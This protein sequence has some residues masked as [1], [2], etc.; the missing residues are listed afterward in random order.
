MVMVMI[1]IGTVEGKVASGI[2][3]SSVLIAS[4]TPSNYRFGRLGEGRIDPRMCLRYLYEFDLVIRKPFV[5]M[6]RALKS[7]SINIRSSR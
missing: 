6:V 5:K 2:Y 4:S 7:P 1:Y 3:T